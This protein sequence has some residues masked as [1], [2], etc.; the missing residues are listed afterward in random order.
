MTERQITKNASAIRTMLTAI[1]ISEYALLRIVDGTKH[2][3]KQRVKNAINSCRIVQ[4]YFLT[5]ENAS[6]ET[7]A[8][9][10]EQFLS[11]EIVL[12]SELLET[13]YGISSEGLEEIINAIK[14]NTETVPSE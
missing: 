7:K 4:Q 6:P 2:N 1:V 12:L 11:D 5:H 10:K 14:Q 13:C 8:M 9:F 3:L